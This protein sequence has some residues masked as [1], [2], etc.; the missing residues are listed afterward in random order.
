[1]NTDKIEEAFWQVCRDEWLFDAASDQWW[2][3]SAQCPHGAW[4]AESTGL[5]G[6]AQAMKRTLKAVRA[7]HP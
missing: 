6:L 1:M 4:S 7:N 2:H 5:V 3:F